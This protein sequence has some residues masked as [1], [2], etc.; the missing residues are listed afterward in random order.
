M[1]IEGEE[2]NQKTLP[3]GIGYGKNHI[4]GMLMRNV[5]VSGASRGIGRAIALE[6]GRRGYRVLINYLKEEERA[7]KLAEEVTRAGGEGLLYRAN[8]ASFEEV[9]GMV[10]S[11]AQEHGELHGIVV[12]AGI[13]IRRNIREMS[14]EDWKRTMDVN[15]NGAFYL[16]KAALPHMHSGS[17]VFV[18]SQLAFR[19]S[20]S[21]VAYSASKAG[22]LGLMRSLALQ[23]AP[24]IRVNA[25]APGT[26]DTDMISSYTPE[27]RKRR[28]EEIPLKR[29]GKPEEVAKAVAF[30]LSDDASY[31]TGATLDVN[32]GIYIR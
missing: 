17:I 5:I 30:L 29:I 32:G 7:K 15:L 28:E 21:S 9:K 12:N 27:M 11:F 25:V 8:M 20:P 4:G 14:M 24:D 10:E 31:I 16:V 18:S 26:I 23:L 22:L 6:L 1:V 3:L 2:F 19:G 13:Y